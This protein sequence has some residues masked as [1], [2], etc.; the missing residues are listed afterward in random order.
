MMAGRC[1]AVRLLVFT[2]VFCDATSVL[3]VFSSERTCNTRRFQCA[4]FPLFR[5]RPAPTAAASPPP[6]PCAQPDLRLEVLHFALVRL[7]G[8]DVLF[9]QLDR[10][11]HRPL[12]LLLNDVS[13][14]VHLRMV[15]G[16]PSSIRVDRHLRRRDE[17]R[18]PHQHK[19][20]AHSSGAVRPGE[21]LSAR[22]TRG[23]SR[24]LH[25]PAAGTWRG[26][27]KASSCRARAAAGRRLHTAP[28]GAPRQ[29]CRISRAAS[30]APRRA[31]PHARDHEGQRGRWGWGRA[32]STL[33]LLRELLRFSGAFISSSSSWSVPSTRLICSATESMAHRASPL[34]APRPTAPLVPTSPPLRDHLTPTN[35]STNQGP[36]V[37]L[38]P[39][40]VLPK[41]RKSV[42]EV[43]AVRKRRSKEE[44]KKRRSDLSNLGP[45]ISSSQPSAPRTHPRKR[46]QHGWQQAASASW[47]AGEPTR[48]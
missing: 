15:H 8:F 44:V 19:H 11:R 36:I 38:G 17:P 32:P 3:T 30:A 34:P 48:C 33:M 1:S 27:T 25:A 47:R 45:D 5:L 37:V 10:R 39:R 14:V 29:P 7:A 41:G 22:G 6:T 42:A 40:V 12:D 4:N 20:L 9:L 13:Q 24:R 16:Y 23:V 35:G 26:S 18:Q 21:M 43:V 2:S 28:H 46:W 31:A